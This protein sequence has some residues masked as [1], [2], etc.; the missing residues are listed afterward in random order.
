MIADTKN[1]AR[2]WALSASSSIISTK[3]LRRVTGI[4]L[5]IDMDVFEIGGGAANHYGASGGISPELMITAIALVKKYIPIRGCAIASYDPAFDRD[6]K[7]LEAGLQ[8]IRQIVSPSL[9]ENAQ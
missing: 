1:S 3:N 6:R 4:Y 8:S 7:F 5:H 2:G 9:S